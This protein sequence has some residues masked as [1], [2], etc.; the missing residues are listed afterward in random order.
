[1]ISYDRSRRQRRCHGLDPG[2]HD[3]LGAVGRQCCRHWPC[4]GRSA[5]RTAQTRDH[6]R[7]SYCNRSSDRMRQHRNAIAAVFW[8]STRRRHSS[9]LGLLEDVARASNDTKRSARRGRD[10]GGVCA[11]T[12][13]NSGREPQSQD[14]RPG[15]I[16]DRGGRH[17]DVFGQRV[18][19]RWAAGKHRL[20]SDCSCPLR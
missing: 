10:V 20:L 12:Q 5:G 18:G 16:A 13:R 1:M 19:H 3:Q 11:R 2:G 8:A 7:N 14:T 9:P 15:H 6:N 17:L 4:G